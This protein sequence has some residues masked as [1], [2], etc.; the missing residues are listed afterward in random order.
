MWKLSWSSKNR[1]HGVFPL[2]I[3]TGLKETYFIIMNPLICKSKPEYRAHWDQKGAWTESSICSQWYKVKTDKKV[4]T[5]RV[6]IRPNLSNDTR[7]HT[8]PISLL[9]S[10]HYSFF[11]CGMK[12]RNKTYHYIFRPELHQS[13]YTHRSYATSAPHPHPGSHSKIWYNR[14][15]NF[16]VITTSEIKLGWDAVLGQGEGLRLLSFVVFNF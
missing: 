2:I 9:L 4:V 7:S 15:F 5:W 1:F 6:N 8:L 14:M 10:L 16:C 13:R 12:G 11:R 3:F